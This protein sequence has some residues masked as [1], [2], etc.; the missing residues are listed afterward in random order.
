[1][2]ILQTW[3]ASSQMFEL[4]VNW[5]VGIFLETSVLRQQCIV[6]SGGCQHC[7]ATSVICGLRLVQKEAVD[8]TKFFFTL[9]SKELLAWLGSRPRTYFNS[10]LLDAVSD[11][12]NTLLGKGESYENAQSITHLLVHTTYRAVTNSEISR[13]LGLIRRALIKYPHSAELQLSLHL[14]RFFKQTFI[15]R[16]LGWTN[17]ARY[18]PMTRSKLSYGGY[19]SSGLWRA[20]LNLISVSSSSMSNPRENKQ[21]L[22][23]RISVEKHWS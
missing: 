6:E 23:S 10:G 19:V 13:T 1:M 3:L 15:V 9:N 22:P 8:V 5:G 16:S 2:R 20:C 11:L 4:S 12:V 21:M 14:L 18:A 7:K 17:C